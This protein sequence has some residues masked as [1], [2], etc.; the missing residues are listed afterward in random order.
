[1]C[2]C[3]FHPNHDSPAFAVN[4]TTGQYICF[5]ASCTASRGGQLD[6]LVSLL[7]KKTI[8]QARRV[9]LTHDNGS[10]ED[11]S[12]IIDDAIASDEVKFI[13]EMVIGDREE[14]FWNNESAVEYMYSRGFNDDTLR[15]FRTGWDQKTGMVVVPIFDAKGK[16]INYNG[17]SITEKKFKVGSMF[18]RNKMLFNINNAKRYPICIITESQFDAMRIHQAG[19][20]NA[21]STLG[22]HCSPEQEGM[23]RRYFSEI[24][25]FG[26]NDSKHD[27]GQTFM[28]KIA[29]ALSD[30][31]V[32]WATDG[33]DSWYPRGCKDAGDMTDDEIRTCIKSAISD[34][35][36]EFLRE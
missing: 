1:M 3:P 27:A 9:I 16:C 36:L 22:D 30:K 20:P 7:K 8:S 6:W 32:L 15:H 14:Q 25:L 10:Q 17:R 26:D 19:Y 5:N 35:E 23:I 18:P 31:S 33:S 11:L 28:R 2:Y 13:P 4:K 21:V 34:F 24:I 12:K 29:D